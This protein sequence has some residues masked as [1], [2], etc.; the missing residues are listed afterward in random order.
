MG[1][2]VH[3]YDFG[4]GDQYPFRTVRAI[5]FEGRIS[6]EHDIRIYQVVEVYQGTQGRTEK[7]VAIIAS[8]ENPHILL[9]SSVCGFFGGFLMRFCEFKNKEVINVCDCQKLGHVM[10]WIFDE[11]SGCIEA[12]IV[13]KSSFFCG[14]FGDGVEYIIPFKCIKKIGRDIIL[15]EI[16]EERK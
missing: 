15:V 9:I 10:D 14:W 4:N 16:H 7:E 11:C 3:E 12:I 13:P 8:E 2:M 1:S 5:G 6:D